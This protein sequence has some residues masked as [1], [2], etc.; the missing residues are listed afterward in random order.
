MKKGSLSGTA[1]DLA[2]VAWEAT[3]SADTRCWGLLPDKIQFLRIE[4][5]IGIHDLELAAATFNG[6]IAPVQLQ[7]TI[8]V[9][10]GRN[11]YVLA[12]FPDMHPVGKLL[13]SQ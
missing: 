10:D 1:L 6:Q 8:E 9:F 4:L 2:G 3:E 12:T 13:V 11:T 5:P 7:Q